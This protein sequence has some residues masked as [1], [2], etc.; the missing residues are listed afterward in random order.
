MNKPNL[1]TLSFKKIIKRCFKSTVF[2]KLVD[3]LVHA[4]RYSGFF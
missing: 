3:N 4:A 2:K 1:S